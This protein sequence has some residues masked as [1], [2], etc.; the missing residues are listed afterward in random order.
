MSAKM[1]YSMRRQKKDMCGWMY[2]Y[3][4]LKTLNDINITCVRFFIFNVTTR[5]LRC[6]CVLN[7]VKSHKE[8]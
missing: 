5:D 1:F 4:W 6:V 8:D 3:I 2:L 7:Y